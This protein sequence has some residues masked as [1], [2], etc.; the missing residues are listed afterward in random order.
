MKI[1]D[2]MAGWRAGWLA[3]LVDRSADEAPSNTEY[4]KCQKEVKEEEVTF[5]MATAYLKYSTR[6]AMDRER[7]AEG[8]V[9]A[10][11]KKI[12]ISGSLH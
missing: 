1:N 11:M 9:V 4:L 12:K 8:V 5:A 2:R 3:S 6:Q 7:C 10:V